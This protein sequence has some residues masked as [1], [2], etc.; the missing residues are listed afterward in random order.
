MDIVEH[1]AIGDDAWDAFCEAS[2]QAW[3]RHTSRGRRVALA[4]SPANKDRSFGVMRQGALA[5]VAPLVT[6]PLLEGGGCGSGGL[7]FAFSI[8]TRASDTHGLATPMPAGE[9]DALAVC[10]QEI[11]RRAKKHGIARA[12]LFVDPLTAAPAANPLPAFGYED[13]SITTSIIDLRA[14]EAAILARMSKGHRLDIA[15]AGRQ[16]HA[17]SI[18][19]DAAGVH[20]FLNLDGKSAANVFALTYK[21]R[22]Y[23][24]RSNMEPEARAL[25]GVGQLLQWRM[26]QELK[27]RGFE[28]YDMG[29][30]SGSS[31]KDESIASFKGRFGGDP[32]P[33][34]YGIKKY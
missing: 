26:M 23:Y 31:K 25:R 15:F 33:L 28:R 17:V 21:R 34:W 14:E 4:L 6:Q 24:G 11:D 5:A 20:A 3:L 10:M 9:P 19:S 22:A 12:R 8:N 18:K 1:Q 13:R 29:W 2:P 30:Q 16:N 32:V 7:E 27:R